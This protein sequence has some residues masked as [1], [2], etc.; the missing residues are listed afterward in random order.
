MR[1]LCFSTAQA[2]ITALERRSCDTPRFAILMRGSVSSLCWLRSVDS[3]GEGSVD[4]SSAS[5]TFDG[6]DP[7]E[8]NG[9]RI[10]VENVGSE[11]DPALVLMHSGIA[12]SRMWDPIIGQLSSDHRVVRYDCR[13]FGRTTTDSSSFSDVDDL[14]AVMA[15]AGV[16]H[17]TLIGASWGGRIAIDAT[18]THPSRVDGLVTIGSSPSGFPDVKLGEQEQAASDRL[19]DLRAHGD[20]LGFNRMQAE[21]WAAGTTRRLADLDPVFVETSYSLN[22]ENISH[23]RETLIRIPGI[24]SAYGRTDAITVP[25]LFVI[26][27]HDLTP[28][29]AAS[30]YLHSTVPNSQQARFV[31]AAHSPS[32]ERPDEFAH[33]LTTWL[34]EHAL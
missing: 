11:R 26:G 12:T 34:A 21:L 7:V 25:S 10:W 24:E 16:E 20:H 18:L 4:D 6:M 14:L 1:A 15:A 22:A 33:I 3:N 30:D 23:A 5:A 28:A 17:A 31:G 32:I 9:A 27:E 29:R 19:D 2:F 8:F 13:G